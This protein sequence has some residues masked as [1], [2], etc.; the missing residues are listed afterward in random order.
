LG[1]NQEKRERLISIVSSLTAK[2]AQR[3]GNWVEQKVGV[4]V[5]ELAKD[6]SDA[7]ELPDEPSQRRA[8]MLEQYYTRVDK[9]Q[10]ALVEVFASTPDTGRGL[11]VVVLIDELDRCDPGEAFE[12]MKQLRIL[13]NMRRLPIVFVLVANPEPIGMAIRHQYGLGGTRGEYE[14][15]RILEKF[16]DTYMDLSEEIPLAGYV[17]GI[18]ER[19][20]PKRLVKASFIVGLDARTE[21]A[22]GHQ[23][24][25]HTV[26]NATALE[27]MS[28]YHPM[29]ANL[30]AMNKT[31]VLTATANANEDHLWTLWHLTMLKQGDPSLRRLV[32]SVPHELR[33][34]ADSATLEVLRVL[35]KCGQLSDGRPNSRISLAAH[36]RHAPY[37]V[38]HAAFWDAMHKLTDEFLKSAERGKGESLAS[39][40]QQI[41]TMDF[42]IH[43]CLFCLSPKGPNGVRVTNLNASRL[44]DAVEGAG[45][46]MD[47]LGWLLAQY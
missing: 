22:E 11:P 20:L 47:H 9:A 43:T 7:G 4:N 5:V 1:K 31:L 29:Y 2:H 24:E 16:V 37:A 39:L 34:A 21:R 40:K 35:S 10:D 46:L 17:K 27:S 13:F 6:I 32:A 26:Y 15:L 25:D 42:L 19:L 45:P 3:F 36:D 30:R 14:A 28:S 23:Y 8:E 33:T 41:E 18:W 44:A 12:A 38:F